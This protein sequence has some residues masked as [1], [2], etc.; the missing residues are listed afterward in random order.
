MSFA[1]LFL[2]RARVK[3]EGLRSPSPPSKLAS[4]VG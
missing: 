3:I 4:A 1:L 2:H